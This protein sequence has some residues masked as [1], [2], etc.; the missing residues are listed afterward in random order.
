MT[1]A[2]DFV[3]ALVGLK[4]SRRCDK[5]ETPRV[6][7]TPAEIHLIFA[8]RCPNNRGQLLPFWAFAIRKGIRWIRRDLPRRCSGYFG[9]GN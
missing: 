8:G 7:Q 9:Y 5:I 3:A 6:Q 4:P 1:V 2:F